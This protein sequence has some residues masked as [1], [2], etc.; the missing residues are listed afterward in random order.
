MPKKQLL[1][2]N[3]EKIINSTEVWARDNSRQFTEKYI[4]MVKWPRSES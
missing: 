2:I 1:Q 3:K 4:Q